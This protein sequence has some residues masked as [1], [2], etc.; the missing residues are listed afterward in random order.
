MKLADITPVYKKNNPLDK[1]NYRPVGLLP[2]ASKIF[3]KIMQKQINDFIVSF[4][5]PYF[6]GYRKGFNTQHALFTLAK[7][8]RESLDNKGFCGAKLMNLSK[9]FDTLNHD[10]L[11]AKL[12]TYGF[13]HDALKLFH[14]YLSKQW[15]RTKVNT[16]FSSWEELIKGKPQGFVLGPILFNLYLND[17]FYLSDF[18]EVCNFADDTKFFACDNDLNNLIKRLEH[19]AFLAIE[20]FETNDMKLNKDKC[21]L[22]VSGHKYENVWVKMEDEKN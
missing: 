11:I 14:S 13:Q 10:L 12:H 19:D 8:W 4:L 21:H 16:P 3:E 2:V 15:H 9:A 18:T 6:C 22:L 5:S 20:W 1:T 7:N 17:L